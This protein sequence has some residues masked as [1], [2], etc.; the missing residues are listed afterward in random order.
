MVLVAV[1]DGCSGF[2]HKGEGGIMQGFGSMRRCRHLVCPV[3]RDGRPHPGIA[4]RAWTPAFEPGH[5]GSHRHGG[6]LVF[7]GKRLVSQRGRD[8]VFAGWKSVS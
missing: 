2:R 8:L 1:S 7:G 4:C 5:K 3:N 6:R